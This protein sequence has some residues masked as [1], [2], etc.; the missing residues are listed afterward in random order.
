VRSSPPDALPKPTQRER[1]VDAMI[2]I[3]A[4]DGYQ[5]VSIAQV[6]THAGVSSATFYDQ[7]EGKEDCL[8]AAYETARSRIYGQIP[9]VESTSDWGNAAR[10]TLGALS[11]LLQRDPD[12]GRVLFVEALAG[13]PVM[14]EE[15]ERV[16]S[17]FEGRVQRFMEGRPKGTKTLDIPIAALEGARRYIVSRHLRTHSEDR[18]PSVV[19]DLVT[20][21]GSYEVPAGRTLWSTGPRSLMR[22]TSELPPLPRAA[23]SAQAPIRLPRGRHGLPPGVVTR[24]RRMRIIRGTAEVM[25]EKG[26][27]NAT[28]ADIVAA[29]GVARD[30]FYEHFENKQHAFAEAQQYSTQYVFDVCGAAYFQARSWPE[31]VWS[32]LRAL[33]TLIV[34]YPA[35]AHLR[36]VECYAAGPSAVRGT[37]ELV[38]GAAVFLEEGYGY[39]PEARQLPR[40]CS[41]AI[42]GAI[43][44]VIYRNVSRGEVGEVPRQLPKLAYLAIAPFTGPDAAIELAEQLKRE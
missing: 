25:Y 11:T 8:L 43:F 20:W 10:A 21:M 12:A 34:S 5:T 9:Q 36:I 44:E 7:F 26:Y 30:V 4:K 38:R 31:R 19:E 23:E 41:Q 33:T 40:I 1:L 42:A 18:L 29:A 6:S 28:V 39:R 14:R 15:R 24:S 35:L 13:G 2:E 17:Q 3:C 16:L 27:A 22:A 32:T 37:E